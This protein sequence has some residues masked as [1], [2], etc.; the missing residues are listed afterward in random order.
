MSWRLELHLSQQPKVT[1]VG[2]G[3]SLRGRHIVPRK[4][5]TACSQWVARTSLDTCAAENDPALEIY[6]PE[7]SRIR[8]GQISNDAWLAHVAVVGLVTFE[9]VGTY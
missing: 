7:S 8:G 5:R 1:T 2:A 6:L 4:L 3:L 9:H